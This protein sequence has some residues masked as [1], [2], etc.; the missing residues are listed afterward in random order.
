MSPGVRA[1]FP[2]ATINDRMGAL[3]SFSHANSAAFPADDTVAVFHVQHVLGG[4]PLHQKL[5]PLPAWHLLLKFGEREH[6][7]CTYIIP[8]FA[9]KG[10]VLMYISKQSDECSERGMFRVIRP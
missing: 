7:F 8:H 1:T 5:L 2:I 4:L 6:S 3:A 9:D 10:G